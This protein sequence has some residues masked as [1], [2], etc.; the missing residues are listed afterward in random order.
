MSFVM[1]C[2]KVF[3]KTNSWLGIAGSTLLVIYLILVTFTQ[4]KNMATI[5]AMPG[6]LM[7]MAWMI[8]FTI[9]LFKL[10]RSDS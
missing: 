1:L 8:L 6:G 4:G 2:G 10:S 7:S 5:L 9:K 3:S